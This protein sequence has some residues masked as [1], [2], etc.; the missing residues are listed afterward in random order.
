LE[1]D[2]G[3]AGATPLV[4]AV[5]SPRRHATNG[6]GPASEPTRDA[7]SSPTLCSNANYFIV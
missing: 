5:R 6:A 1:C 3:S 7:G 4:R 2:A